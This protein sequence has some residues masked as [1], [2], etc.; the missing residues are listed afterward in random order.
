TLM[1]VWKGWGILAILVCA[2]PSMII[3]KIL[4]ENYYLFGNWIHIVICVLSAVLCFAIGRYLNT[5]PGKL[6]VEANTGK[7]VEV[8]KVHSIFFIKFEYWGIIYVLI[9]I[10]ELFLK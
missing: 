10:Y 2:L 5:R 7:Q 1:I 4:G 9:N 3:S 8:K 6:Y